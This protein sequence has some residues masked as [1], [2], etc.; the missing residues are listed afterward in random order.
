MAVASA[1]RNLHARDWVRQHPETLK[2]S[3]EE[4]LAISG[5]KNCNRKAN[6]NLKTSWR[7]E[8]NRRMESTGITNHCSLP[9]CV[10]QFVRRCRRRSMPTVISHLFCVWQSNKK[11]E[12]IVGKIS[13]DK[14]FLG[15][16]RSKRPFRGELALFFRLRFD[17]I[18]S[19]KPPIDS[20]FRQT[21]FLC[22]VLPFLHATP[23]LQVHAF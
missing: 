16:C 14:S 15:C 3:P 19:K 9:N 23:I 12:K 2:R 10:R 7:K 20:F 13:R 11:A 1:S 18:Y 17:S 4:L 21:T 5:L 6:W 22:T 8:W